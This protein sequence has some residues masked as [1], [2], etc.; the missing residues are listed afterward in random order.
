VTEDESGA[1]LP[2]RGEIWRKVLHLLSLS[3]PIGLL[4]LGRRTALL[5]L[6]PLAIL[7]VAG[8]ILR[9]RSATVRNLI[10]KTVGFMMRREEIPPIPTPISFNGATWVLL[11]ACTVAALFE[12][13]IAAA[14]L[15][16]GLVGDAAAALIGRRFGRHRFGRRGKSIEGG[17]AFAVAAF[18]AVLPVP[19]LPVL[20]VAVAVLAAAFVEG[21][22]GPVNDNL[23]VPLAAGIVLTFV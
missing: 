15:I 14:S 21:A 1:S 17:I 6:L 11:G 22:G 20:S 4:L 7:F 23:S 12:P 10:S 2:Y 8:E 13:R 3:I 19:G 9:T 18:V 5:I 16:I